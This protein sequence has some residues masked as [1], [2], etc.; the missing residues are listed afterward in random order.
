M[1]G[2][3]TCALPIWMRLRILEDAAVKGTEAISRVA[4]VPPGRS[5]RI[6]IPVRVKS[7]LKD[8]SLG[9]EFTGPPLL[10][11]QHPAT[12]VDPRYDSVAPSTTYLL[13]TVYS[14]NRIRAA[15]DN[16]NAA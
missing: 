6:D 5:G 3:Q 4:I 12:A 9:V 2:V 16:N 15:T 1:T 13:S 14:N 8:K 7:K 11:S 10:V